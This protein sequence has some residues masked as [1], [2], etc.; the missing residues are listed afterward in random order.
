MKKKILIIGYGNI[1]LRHTQSLFKKNYVIYI[2]DPKIDHIDKLPNSNKKN[3]FYF[4]DTKK[5]KEKKFDL[6]ISATTSQ[7]RYK[8]TLLAIKNFQIKN[9]IFEKVVFNKNNEFVK[10]EKILKKNK[11]KSWVNCPLRNMIVF[12]RIKKLIKQSD[13]LLV[14]VKGSRWNMASN[15]IHYLDLYNYFDNT[16]FNT[17]KNK[18]SKKIYF[19][20]RKGFFELYGQIEFLINKKKFLLLENTKKFITFTIDIAFDNHSFHLAFAKRSNQIKHYF[21]N[22]LKKKGKFIIEKQSNM[23]S[24]VVEKIFAHKDPGLISFTK[25]IILHR[26]MIKLLSHHKKRNLKKVKSYPIT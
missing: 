23:T 11:I 7:I 6:L 15:S 24:K 14:I 3:I 13:K 5:I 20:K 18:L 9:I 17:F 12:K 8:T 1:G 2:V 25:S 22:K 4:N 26:I 19:S 21:K 16:E 10:M